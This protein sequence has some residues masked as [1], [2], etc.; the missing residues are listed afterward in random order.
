M[1]KYF[2][3]KETLSGEYDTQ[4]TNSRYKGILGPCKRG[5]CPAHRKAGGSP[6]V[7]LPKELLVSPDAE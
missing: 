3:A 7:L 5:V 4:I 6:G 1:N 2:R